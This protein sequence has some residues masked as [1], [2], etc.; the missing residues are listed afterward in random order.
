LAENSNNR[1]QEKLDYSKTF[2][3]KDF[4][5]QLNPNIYEYSDIDVTDTRKVTER[6]DYFLLFEFSAKWDPVPTMCAKSYEHD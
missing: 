6:D 1:K 3:F 2:A 5:L 4:K